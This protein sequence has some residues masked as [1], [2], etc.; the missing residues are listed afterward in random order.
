[1]LLFSVC[2]RVYAHA[3][4]QD[5]CWGTPESGIVLWSFA[6]GLLG[7]HMSATGALTLLGSTSEPIGPGMPPW[8]V[9]APLPPTWPPE[10]AT[11]VVGQVAVRGTL[12]DVSCDVAQ[13]GAADARAPRLQPSSGHQS[14]GTITCTTA[15][16]SC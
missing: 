5:V 10:V 3:H 11:V 14:Q 8:R 15:V 9:T 7:L 6:K 13:P 1:M 12:V 16:S 4:V 2:L